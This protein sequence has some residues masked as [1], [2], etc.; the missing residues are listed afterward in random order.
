M[1]LAHKRNQN[2]ENNSMAKLTNEDVIEII[3][4][5]N[6]PKKERDAK[7]AR[8]Y[9]VTRKTI[10]NIRLNRTWKHINRDIS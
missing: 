6:S 1:L 2:G 5:L 9:G 8:D 3:K 7:I 4:R 10:T